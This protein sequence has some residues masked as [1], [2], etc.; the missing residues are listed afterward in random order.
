MEQDLRVNDF[1]LTEEQKCDWHKRN[2]LYNTLWFAQN[3]SY[4]PDIEYSDLAISNYKEIPCYKDWGCIYH[5]GGGKV[6]ITPKGK[7]I[8][9]DLMTGWWNP[10]KYFL[11]LPI[12]GRQ[13]SMEKLLEEVPKEKDEKDRI[14]KWIQEKN[15]AA[16]E[17]CNALLDFLN[18][19][20]TSGNIIPDPINW[21]SGRGIDSWEYKLHKIFQYQDDSTSDDANVKAW[22]DYIN[23]IFKKNSL[24]ENRKFFIEEN[25]LQMY[26]KDDKFKDDHIVSFWGKKIPSGIAAATTEQWGNYFKITKELISERNKCLQ[27]IY[28]KQT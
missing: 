13:E 9:A 21:I 1:Y 8:T 3:K 20:Y 23:D 14:I 2:I 15:N 24:E 5:S 16:K 26:F 17:E 19:V 28:N 10:F 27:A 4:M 7:I 12:D 25:R 18:V 6:L 22:N 11:K